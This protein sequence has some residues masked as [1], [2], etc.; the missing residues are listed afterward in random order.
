MCFL[1]ID[2]SEDYDDIDYYGAFTVKEAANPEIVHIDSSN[3]SLE[4]V[5][6]IEPS[7]A[8]EKGSKEGYICY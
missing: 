6:R 1:P 2:G 8:Q 3:P 5:E 7:Q 4:G